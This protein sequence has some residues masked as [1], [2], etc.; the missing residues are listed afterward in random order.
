MKITKE[1]ITKKDNNIISKKSE[2][3]KYNHFIYD[4]ELKTPKDIRKG[5]LRDIE[6]A[7]KTAFS[8]LQN[9]NINNFGLNERCKKDNSCQ[10]IE[11]PNTA[12]KII[13][14]G[15]KIKGIKIYSDY[16]KDII[17]I[18]K[19]SLKGINLTTIEK[20][21]RLKKENNIWILCIPLNTKIEENINKKKTCAFDPGIRKFQTIYSEE[22]SFE[23]TANLDKL[24][25]LYDK[26][27]KSKAQ[28]KTKEITSKIF[29]KR[30]V[31]YSSRIKNLIDDMHYK[32]IS[33]ATKNFS[34]ILLPSFET[35]DMVSNRNLSKITKRDM[36]TFSFYKFRQRL[37]HKC[38]IMKHCDVTIVNESYTSQTCGYCGNLKKTSSEFIICDRCNR[39][40]DRDINGAR[41]IY[42]KYTQ[43]S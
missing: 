5:A 10:S 28:R 11:I 14:S 32:T 18:S 29:K 25:K 19:K 36:N 22:A 23:I 13:K 39:T 2:E 3:E 27:D 1:Y 6:K 15:I 38:K 12:I 4:W 30:S 40:F 17:K 24:H 9:G 33:F 21:C 34:H 43:S 20:Y 31:K 16:C 35:Q 42:L 37:E 7:F 8:N 41:N 26:I